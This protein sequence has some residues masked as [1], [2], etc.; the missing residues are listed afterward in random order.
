[1][2]AR[3]RQRFGTH[4]LPVMA[5]GGY[6]SQSY[7]D[8]VAAD[9]ERCGRPA[10]LLYAGDFDPSGEDIDRDFLERSGRFSNVVRVALTPEQ[11]TASTSRPPQASRLPAAPPPSSHGTGPS[12]KSSWKR[13]TRPTC[14]GSRRTGWPRSGT[15]PRLTLP[16]AGAQRPGDALDR[17]P[18]SASL[19]NRLQ[20]RL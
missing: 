8:S 3:L 9:V 14:A 16:C 1:M 13:Q 18:V 10:L 4:G 15:R 11:V 5:L 6:A 12:C 17:R 2:V 20:T 19:P 7:V